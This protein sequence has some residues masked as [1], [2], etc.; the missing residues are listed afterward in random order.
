MSQ[1]FVLFWRATS[2]PSLFSGNYFR[3][4]D[5]RASKDTVQYT[6]AISDCDKVPVAQGIDLTQLL[7]IEETNRAI[8]WAITRTLTQKHKIN[9]IKTTSTRVRSEFSSKLVITVWNGLDVDTDLRSLAPFKNNILAI[10][11]DAHLKC[12][13]S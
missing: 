1:V 13:S 8:E 11:F 7:A 12:F 2:V 5:L 4:C 6:C 3:F 10:D 9:R